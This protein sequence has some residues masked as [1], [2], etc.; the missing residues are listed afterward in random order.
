MGSR[1]ANGWFSRSERG[2][3][4]RLRGGEPIRG[5]FLDPLRTLESL[6]PVAFADELLLG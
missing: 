1:T 5:V 2:L 6:E 3:R 4:P